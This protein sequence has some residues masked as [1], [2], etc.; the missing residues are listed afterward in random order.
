MSKAWT[1]SD[2]A[3]FPKNSAETL[4][5]YASENGKL[6]ARVAELEDYQVGLREG[7]DALRACLNLHIEALQWCS[8]ASDFAPGDDT[9]PPGKAREGW[10]KL[11]APLLEVT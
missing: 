1:E 7:G 4:N 6:R 2:V 8:G 3:S 11:C 10:L 5:A 9:T